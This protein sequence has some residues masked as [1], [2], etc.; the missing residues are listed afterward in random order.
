[1]NDHRSGTTGVPLILM[2]CNSSF[3]IHHSW[4]GFGI[5]YGTANPVPVS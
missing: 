2:R 5:E 1:M 3:I 4:F